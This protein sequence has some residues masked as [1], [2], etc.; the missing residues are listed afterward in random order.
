MIPNKRLGQHFLT[1]PE[2]ITQIINT[3]NPK[4]GDH[5]VEIGPGLGA[6]TTLITPLCQRLDV[7]EIDRRMVSHLKKAATKSLYIHLADALKFDFTQLSSKPHKLRI[8]GNLPYNISTPLL[9]HCLKQADLIQDMHF[10][11]Q[12]EVVE[13]LAAQPDG[14]DYGR[15]SVM[16]QYRCHIEH[17]FNIGAEHFHPQPKVNS[18]V[19]R[20]IPHHTL[21]IKAR[22]E[23]LFRL[24]VKQAFSQ[25]RKKLSNSLK[26]LMTPVE[27]QT[28]DIDSNQR[29]QNLSVADFVK[30]SNFLATKHLA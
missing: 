8:F 26:A 13:R 22:D 15:L 1:S 3:I 21:T 24:V 16:A 27:M 28:I 7:I 25:R 5:L 14:H 30:L 11:L 18:A 20:L 29:A 9:F 17:L 4:N 6:L 23:N 2:I 19:V 12:Q 10:T